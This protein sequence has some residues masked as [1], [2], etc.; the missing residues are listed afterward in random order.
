MRGRIRTALPATERWQEPKERQVRYLKL[1][2]PVLLVLALGSPAAVLG[3]SPDREVLRGTDVDTDFCGTGQ[4]VLLAFNGVINWWEDKGFGH[5]SETWTNP[6]TGISVVTSFAGGGKFKL[7][8]HEDGG[9][10]FVTER[11]GMP[12]K[13]RV[14]GGGVL[15]RDAGL[16]IFYD[17]FNAD[18]EY[19]GTDVVIRG[20]P[21]PGIDPGYDWCDLMIEVLGL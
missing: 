6:E 15:T 8:E 11:M 20:G 4:T 13:I 16:I 19:L 21:H 18:D 3:A 17:H 10:T 12:D 7:I 2:G 14:K 5:L 9:Y 1:I